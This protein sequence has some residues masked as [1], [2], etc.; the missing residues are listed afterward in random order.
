MLKEYKDLLDNGIISQEEYDAHR[1]SI[2]NSEVMK[3]TEPRQINKEEYISYDQ[4][5]SPCMSDINDA[6]HQIIARGQP[7]SEY[8]WLLC[9]RFWYY[10]VN[11]DKD[12]N[13]D[14]RSYYSKYYLTKTG[15]IIRVV[16]LEREILGEGISQRSND[17]NQYESKLDEVMKALDFNVDIWGRESEAIDY[18]GSRPEF[19]DVPYYMDDS[20]A[21][22]TVKRVSEIKGQILL[23]KLNEILEHGT[24]NGL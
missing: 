20:R 23:H 1:R 22:V 11:P 18:H 24:T 10:N 17:V 14:E 12:G 13:W 21:N 15:R 2:L 6:I 19:C 9:S 7:H 8:G 16:E 3:K 5:V 4:E